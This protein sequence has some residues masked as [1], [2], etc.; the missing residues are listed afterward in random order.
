MAT[1]TSVRLEI[2]DM[3]TLK[4]A[5]LEIANGVIYQTVSGTTEKKGGDIRFTPFRDEFL[6][7]TLPSEME[8]NS[9]A[10]S[11]LPGYTRSAITNWFP[12]L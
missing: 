9:V 12:N 4:F 10:F 8:D 5:R 11:A 1:G 7:A 6:P 3:E 2:V